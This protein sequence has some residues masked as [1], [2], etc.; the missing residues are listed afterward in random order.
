MHTRASKTYDDNH[1]ARALRKVIHV[2]PLQHKTI[3]IIAKD[4]TFPKFCN[5]FRLMDTFPSTTYICTTYTPSKTAH[6]IS[7]TNLGASVGR[8]STATTNLVTHTRHNLTRRLLAIIAQILK[9]FFICSHASFCR[10]RVSNTLS[11]VAERAL[12][13]CYQMTREALATVSISLTIR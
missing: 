9:W 7:I 4:R 5:F 2:L 12:R 6:I 3:S 1:R 11:Q 10:L 13:V 8:H